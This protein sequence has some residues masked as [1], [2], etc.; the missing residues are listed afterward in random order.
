VDC[1]GQSFTLDAVAN[2]NSIGVTQCSAGSLSVTV[3]GNNHINSDTT[4]AYDAAGNM[5][6]DGGGYT[7]TF[8]DENHLTLAS[9]MSGGPYCYVYDGNGLRVAKKSGATTCSS[10]TVTKLYWRSIA[11][12]AIAETDSTGSTTNSAYN[13]YVFFGGRRIAS[14]DGTG[15]IY[16]YFADHLGSTRTIT[17]GSGPGQTPGQLCYDADFS[18]YGQEMSHSERLQTTA[19]PPNYKFTGYERDPETGLDYAFARYYSSRL[20]RFLSTD[21]LGGVIGDLQS[22]NAYPYVE[23]NPLNSVDPSGLGPCGLTSGL[24][25]LPNNFPCDKLQG[26]PNLPLACLWCYVWN[27]LDLL[28]LEIWNGEAWVDAPIFFLTDEYTNNHIREQLEN[29]FKDFGKSHCAKVF[30]AVIPGFSAAKFESKASSTNYYDVTSAPANTFTQNDVTGNGNSTPLPQSLPRGATAQTLNGGISNQTAILLG[31]NFFSS[32]L[33]KRGN[34][35]IH[36]AIHAF[37]GWGD[38][39]IFSSF[40]NYGLQQVNQGTGDIS[41]WIGT[42]CSST[43]AKAN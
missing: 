12:D 25:N 2:L 10:G 20:G 36:E 17:T 4:Y 15:N 19:C 13:E 14:R 5:T 8:D 38:P 31:A 24:F 7:Y 32:S 11:G 42:D 6:K 41:S 9:G 28:G 27:P 1:W 40:A 21:P 29:T 35:L 18:P 16:Y 23:N 30:A 37:T 39:G 26:L 43:P 22:H 3:D 33:A 34:T